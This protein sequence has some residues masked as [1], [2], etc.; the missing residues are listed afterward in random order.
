VT[1]LLPHL[2]QA[3]SGSKQCASQRLDIRLRPQE[4]VHDDASSTRSVDA[5]GLGEAS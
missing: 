2:L 5:I 4:W 3:P 1:V